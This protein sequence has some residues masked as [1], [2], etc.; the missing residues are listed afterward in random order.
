VAVS[1]GA[2]IASHAA[3]AA[4]AAQRVVGRLGLDCAGM[5]VLHS[6]N[7]TTIHF[8]ACGL[9]AKVGTSSEAP[10]TFAREIAVARYLGARGAEIACPASG[11]FAGPY[12]QE[13]LEIT[14]WEFVP[15]EFDP[16]LDDDVFG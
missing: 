3:A 10:E 2:G 5:D 4:L 6:S 12:Q 13:G 1:E 9:V 16:E 14:L 11:V 7:D 15:H 8:P